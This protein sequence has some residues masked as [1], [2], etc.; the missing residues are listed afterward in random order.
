LGEAERAELVFL[1]GT[2]GLHDVAVVPVQDLAGQ[3]VSGLADVQL[4][5]DG[6]PVRFVDRV[7]HGQQV[8]GLGDAAVLGQGVAE[9]GGVSVAGQHP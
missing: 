7:D 6:A 5:G 3:R 2:V 9:W 1:S 8:Q 4:P